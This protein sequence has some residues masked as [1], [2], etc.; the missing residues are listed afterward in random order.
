MG[1]NLEASDFI[2]AGGTWSGLLFSNRAF[3]VETQL[4]LSFDFDFE[5]VEVDGDRAALGLTVEWAP[6]PAG[7]TWQHLAG[8]EVRCS[9][10]GEPVQASVYY[11]EHHCFDEVYLKVLEQT[12]D[13]I[14][15][16]V[17]VFG[18]IDQ[19][20]IPTLTAETWLSF[21]GIFVQNEPRPRS[22]PEAAAALNAWTSIEGLTGA[23]RGFNYL[24]TPATPEATGF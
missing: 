22:L 4:T 24:F 15:V 1:K 19:L 13:K 5:E 23:D 17:A 9:T 10:F 21:S 16:R 20:G 14:R 2:P 12:E 6:W 8:A 18:D 11:Y 7:L 3:G